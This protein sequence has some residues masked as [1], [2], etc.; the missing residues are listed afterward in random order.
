MIAAEVR[1]P[2]QWAVLVLLLGLAVFWGGVGLFQRYAA[3]PAWVSHARRTS[4]ENALPMLGLCFLG[5]A[6]GGVPMPFG[7]AGAAVPGLFMVGGFLA[8]VIG[9][10]VYFPRMFLPRWY[11]RARRAGVDVRDPD[12]VQRFRDG[13]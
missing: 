4:P 12:A 1:T 2:M 6:L 9:S 8:W 11:R 13:Q 5:M 7:W 10:W 3:P